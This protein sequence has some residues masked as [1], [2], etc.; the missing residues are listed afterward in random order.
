MHSRPI[1]GDYK[2]NLPCQNIPNFNFNNGSDNKLF[3]PEYKLN[4]QMIIFLF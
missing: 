4:L 1:Q 2:F 3:L